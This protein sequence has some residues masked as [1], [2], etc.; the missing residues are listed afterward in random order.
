M[1]RSLITL[2]MAGVA[3]LGLS[4]CSAPDTAEGQERQVESAFNQELH[5][6]LPQEIQDAGVISVAGEV[7][8]PWR[9][10]DSNG[11]VSGFQVEM[12]K[13]FSEVLGVQL[14]SDMVNGLPGVKLGVQSDRNDLGF[15]PLLSNDTTRQEL[16]FI[17][18]TVGRPSFVFPV[19]GEGM[20]AVTDLCGQTVSHLEGSVAFENALNTIDKQ[21]AAETAP[22]VQ[23]LPLADINAVILSLESGR[24]DYGGMG[25]HQAAYTQSGNPDKFGMYISTDEEFTPD[26]LGMGFDPR[27]ADL[28]EVMLDAWKVVF[29][30]GT[31]DELMDKYNMQDIKIDEPELHLDAAGQ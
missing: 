21:C 24:A 3:L 27:D 4:A 15:G 10:L 26:R 2:A 25:A 5:D 1:K 28:A 9:V 14:R 22:K 23:R 12:L 7:N 30:N 8:Q 11:E 6:R 13:E 17:D 31:Y 18:Y 19:D 16:L 20:D 29:E